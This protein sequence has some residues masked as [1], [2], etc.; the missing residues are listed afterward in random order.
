MYRWTRPRIAVPAHGEALHLAEHAKFARG[1]GVPDVVAATNGDMVRLAP[2]PAGVIDD[3]PAGRLYKDGDLVIGP[4]DRRCRS[5]A[6]SPSPASSGRHRHRRAAARS[7]G[8]PAHGRSSACRRDPQT[9][10]RSRT[11]SRTR[12]RD[13]LDGLSKV[14]RR[15]PERSRRPSSARSAAR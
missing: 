2:G 5:G 3:V 8:D 1:V 12:R 11:S 6:S 4:A 14:K 10:S 13:V 15:D 7:L 9:A